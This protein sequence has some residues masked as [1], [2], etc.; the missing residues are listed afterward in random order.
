[1]LNRSRSSWCRSP[2]CVQNPRSSPGGNQAC[3][4]NRTPTR[5][6]AGRPAR[7]EPR[8]K[9]AGRHRQLNH[10]RNRDPS[11]VPR[12]GRSRNRFHA[13]RRRRQ[14]SPESNPPLW[15]RPS[16]DR[17][18]AG[19]CDSAGP[20]GRGA[21]ATTVGDQNRRSSRKSIAGNL[22]SI[23]IEGNQA[24]SEISPFGATT[25]AGRGRRK[26]LLQIAADGKVTGITSVK[27][28]RTR[29]FSTK[30]R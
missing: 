1:M 14:F 19:R 17:S 10:A 28:Q 11:R 23:N 18:R 15:R 13:K 29:L 20:A 25:R 2:N 8:P 27:K 16:C 21:A 22:R 30:Q 26:C 5:A 12:S 6:A 24:L 7:V 9:P 3:A 4:E